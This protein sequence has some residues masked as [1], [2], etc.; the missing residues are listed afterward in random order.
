MNT[1]EPSAAELIAVFDAASS[2]LS[3]AQAV[4]RVAAVAR[5][6]ALRRLRQ[7]GYTQAQLGQALRLSSQRVSQLLTKTRED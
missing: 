5:A 3:D 6:H 4:A 7:R 1:R 2:V